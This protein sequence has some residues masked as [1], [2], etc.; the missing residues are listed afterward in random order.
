M[1]TIINGISQLA[2]YAM[3]DAACKELLTYLL[4]VSIYGYLDYFCERQNERE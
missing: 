2:T 4:G 1:N 3:F